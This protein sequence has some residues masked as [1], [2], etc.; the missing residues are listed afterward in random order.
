MRGALAFWV[1]FAKL[2]GGALLLGLALVGPAAALAYVFDSMV[3]FAAVFVLGLVAFV[4]WA[5]W[6]RPASATRARRGQ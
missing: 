3:V 6:E 1:F 5:T 4:T 2:M